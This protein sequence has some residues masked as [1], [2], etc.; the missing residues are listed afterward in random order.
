MV[1]AAG[2]GER[3]RPLTDGTPKPLLRVADKPLIEYHLER[4][5]GAGVREIVVNLGWHGGQ[6]RAALGDGA[7]WGVRI[8][9][10]EEGWPALETGGGILRALPLLGADPFLVVSGDIYSDY[11]V[12]GL[13]ARA[14]TLRATDLAHL[15]LVPRPEFHADF[16][17]QGSR[18]R[19]APAEFTFGNYS[20]LRPELFAECAAG[21]FPIGP[22]WH[23]AADADRV[24]GEV[25]R[26]PWWN[27]GT[28]QQLAELDAA[29]KAAGVGS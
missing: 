12:G 11:P 7:R 6:I 28:P 21:A 19:N 24:S 18:V 22:L 14:R 3:M 13:V 27:L 1:L 17:L 25:Y 23:A 15:V 4:L 5:A 9:Y 16:T 29:L 8:R 10:S 26:G 20:I 2:K